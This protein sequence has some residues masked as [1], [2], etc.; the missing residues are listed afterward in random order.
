[1]EIF[2]HLDLSWPK[3]YLKREFS[4]GNFVSLNL[5]LLY[6]LLHS[7]L[8]PIDSTYI[9]PRQENPFLRRCAYRLKQLFKDS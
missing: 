7:V 6:F 8:L 1:M 5:L 4:C 2:L 3:P 9:E